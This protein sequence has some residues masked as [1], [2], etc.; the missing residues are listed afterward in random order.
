MANEQDFL[1]D[2]KRQAEQLA[3]FMDHQLLDIIAVEGLNHF[4]ESF[5]VEGWVDEALE[6][7]QERK[8]TDTRGRDLTRYRTN[9]VGRSG[10]LTRFGQKNKGRKILT[11]HDSG[12]DK[13]RHSLRAD[14]INAGVEFAT[15][16][17]YAEVHNEGSDTMPQRQFM[18][19]SR[20][21]DKKIIKKTEKELD[22]IFDQ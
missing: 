3:D 17:D 1:Q 19:S 16:K 2:I 22:K 20:T 4:E 18:G 15:D 11:G 9:R 21:L 12:G 14:K 6:P 5:E 8:T 7:W 13:L 10:E